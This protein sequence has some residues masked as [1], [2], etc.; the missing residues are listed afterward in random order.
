V[1][2]RNIIIGLGVIASL[3]FAPFATMGA[4]GDIRDG[5][6]AAVD[7]G[8]I[9][10]TSSQVPTG[11][12]ADCVGLSLAGDSLAGDYDGFAGAYPC[13]NV[14]L[15]GHVT[16]AEIGGGG[17]SD[18]WGWVDDN[19][20]PDDSADDREIALYTSTRGLTYI[21]VTDPNLPV[22]LATSVLTPNDSGALWRDVKV[23]SDH[24]FLVSE[25]GGY[26]MKV[27]D[28]A[29]LR[30]I[31]APGLQNVIDPITTYD[32]FG[33]A[34]N[35][36]IN[37][38]TGRAY[39]VGAGNE[40]DEQ[41]SDG[42][43]HIVD[44]SDPTAPAFLGSFSQDGYTHDAQCVV[45]TGPDTDYNGE[46]DDGYQAELCAAFNE[47]SVS[48]V[49]VTDPTQAVQIAEI[50]YSTAA[51]TH[52]GWFTPDMNF[53]VFNDEL[54]EDGVLGSGTVQNT[55]T[56]MVDVSELDRDE[57]KNGIV[58]EAFLSAPGANN[59]ADGAGAGYLGDFVQRYVHETISIDHNLYITD[60]G[61]EIAND[62]GYIWQANYNA[63][64]QVFRYSD[65]GLAGGDLLR[66]GYFD[67]DPGLNVK[68]Y[69]GAWNV[70]PYFPSGTVI[71]STL[72]EG[73]F[74]L[75]PDYDAMLKHTD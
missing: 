2:N 63:G 58:D 16:L 25:H 7:A 5:K 4:P 72:D 49:D 59:G 64:L 22:V 70:Y 60:D 15:G 48:I 46:G 54:D 57:W 6:A 55:T 47:D 53:I 19:A 10:L 30:A 20:T 35:I 33:S 27:Y 67:V 45:Y 13:M 37:E 42:G 69:G 52:Q 65:A 9:D 24:A 73:L 1:K 41:D 61:D 38:E 14:G 44:I 17:G 62:T 74:V 71:V 40:S 68:A 26:G 39:G 29:E 51:Y 3:A 21:D 32:G 18:S 34:H 66:V 23:Y 8:L 28:L 43:L 12:G 11:V 56:Y 50:R 31:V 75:N 36:V